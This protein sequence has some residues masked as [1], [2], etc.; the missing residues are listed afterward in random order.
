MSIKS[1]LC[2]ILSVVFFVGF[3]VLTIILFGINVFLGVLG[4]VLTLVIPPILV[5]KAYH[6][7]SGIIDKLIVKIIVPVLS[8]IG[9]V[10]VLLIYFL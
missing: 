10:A 5:R 8:L 9:I 7:A 3:V 1:L 4:I 2:S 6:E